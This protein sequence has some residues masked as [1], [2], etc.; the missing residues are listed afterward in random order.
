MYAS[1]IEVHVVHHQ[2]FVLEELGE[3]GRQLDRR[4]TD[5]SFGG[6]VYIR[7]EE[8]GAGS[9]ISARRR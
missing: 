2:V 7:V 3:L 6:L 5:R 1:E 9:S 4:F 8:E